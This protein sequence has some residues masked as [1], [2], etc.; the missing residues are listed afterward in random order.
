VSA[1][2][3]GQRLSAGASGNGCAPEI[4]ALH[5]GNAAA[6]IR[7]LECDHLNWLLFGLLSIVANLGPAW[8]VISP[9]G[10][11]RRSRELWP[12]PG[13]D[14]CVG[15]AGAEVGDGEVAG[16]AVRTDQTRL[17]GRG[18]SIRGVGCLQSCASAVRQ[19]PV[20]AVPLPRKAYSQRLRPA[21]GPY[22]AIIDGWLVADR[23]VPRKQ[24]RTG[25][26]GLAT[27]GRRAGAS[28]ADVTVSRYVPR[29][30]A[31]LGLDKTE[32]T[33]P[34]RTSRPEAEV[35]FGEFHAQVAGI[36][37]KLWMFVMRLSC[38][39]WVFH[40]AFATQAQEA[41]LEGHVLAFEYFGAVPG[42]VR[43]PV[44]PGTGPATGPT[45]AAGNTTARSAC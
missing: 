2:W 44:R 38:S 14:L 31:E 10:V 12:R 37:L 30:R 29:R 4:R 13:S 3:L 36:L 5:G 43:L 16:G 19:A 8:V 42:R 27:A 40:V 20:S 32:V 18:V 23:E 45:V 22:A 24:R 9:D 7:T 15:S 1:F 35:D 11:G 21:I 25:P 17:A 28:V 39:G 6:V 34:Q 41:F 33:V 26:A